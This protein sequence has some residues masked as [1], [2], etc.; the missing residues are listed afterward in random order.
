M[1]MPRP[2]EAHR[3][4]EK[5]VGFWS[6][7]EIMHPSPWDPAGGTAIGRNENRLALDGLAAIGDYEQERNGIITFRGHAVYTYNAPEQCYVCHWFDSMG[8]P[9]NVFRGTFEGDVLTMTCR[10]A[11]G[12]ARLTYDFSE[13]GRIL[14]VMEMSQ[15]GETW[16]AMMEGSYVR[17]D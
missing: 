3:R 16:S 11:Q 15:D 4:L 13:G 8:M 9:P 10:D 1:E 12:H 17:Q 5:L 14:S 6:G 7:E 2:T